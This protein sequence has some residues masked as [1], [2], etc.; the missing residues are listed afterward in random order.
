MYSVY[1]LKYFFWTTFNVDT[2]ATRSWCEFL[3]GTVRLRC[4]F[5][6][7]SVVVYLCMVLVTPEL[8][9]G[10][11]WVRKSLTRV[12]FDFVC[13]PRGP[14]VH[15]WPEWRSGLFCRLDLQ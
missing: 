9:S 3:Y 7:H 13:R 2:R 8:D 6:E 11:S 12:Y 1:L 5:Y 4:E 10:G 15:R 14:D